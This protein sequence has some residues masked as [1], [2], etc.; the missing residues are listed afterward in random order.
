MGC[1]LVQ[2]G[3]SKEVDSKKAVAPTNIS[4]IT[5]EEAQ[6]NL[7][8]LQEHLNKVAKKD[9]SFKDKLDEIIKLNTIIISQFVRELV[10]P[11]PNTDK[12]IIATN[13]IRAIKETGLILI[14]K[15]ESEVSEEIDLNS[16]KFQ[17]IFG[18]F[19]ELIRGVLE[20]QG[21][22]TLQ[23]NNIFSSLSLK[24]SGWEDK[25]VKRLKGISSKALSEVK[26]PLVEKNK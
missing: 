25:I 13:A 16:P 1:T 10:S 23:I 18:W 8:T 3:K 9:L 7:D 24:L 22:N 26:N 20:E 21:L 14:K 5:P 17:L 19:I 4:E 12:S 2:G 6:R 15:H 11:M